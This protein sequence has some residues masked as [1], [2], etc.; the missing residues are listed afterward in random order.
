MGGLETPSEKRV[1]GPSTPVA[2][3]GWLA[4][5]VNRHQTDLKRSARPSLPGDD[6]ATQS[7]G[8]PERMHVNAAE[9][10]C[11][12]GPSTRP[13]SGPCL[14]PGTWR[15]CARAGPPGDPS[16]PYQESQMRLSF[17][18]EQTEGVPVAFPPRPYPA[19]SGH[20][21]LRSGLPSVRGTGMGRPGPAC[22]R[23]SVRLAWMVPAPG[24]RLEAASE[25]HDVTDKA[26]AGSKREAGCA[27]QY[28]KSAEQHALCSQPVSKGCLP[29]SAP[30]PVWRGGSMRV[31]L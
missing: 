13:C 22:L 19:P 3:Q 26:G 29:S 21:P 14:G 30:P 12:H 1:Q 27:P 17:L 5:L 20:C 18:P 9:C 6:A 28:R 8:D 15:T 11:V 4:A 2:L 31:R 16:I 25:G 24:M 10:K 7:R 23:G